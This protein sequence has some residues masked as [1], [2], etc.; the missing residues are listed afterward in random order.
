MSLVENI[1]RR[2]HRAIDLLQDIEGLK[3]RGYGDQEI[4]Q[5]TGLSVTYVAGVIRLIEQ[6]ELRLLR[7]V[8][9]GHIPL[10]V[11]VQIAGTDDEGIQSALQQAYESKILRGRKLIA[12]RR[13]IEARSRRGKGLKNRGPRDQTSQ[14]SS[15]T[16]LRTYKDDVDKKHLMIRRVEAARNQLVFVTEAL[17][18]LFVDEHFVTLLRAEGLENLPKKLAVRMNEQDRA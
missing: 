7:G 10:T 5:K 6:G 15:R 1:A 9:S 3:R 12:A 8:E 16:L 17:R 13:L 4:A 18:S 14:A 11:A 2:Q